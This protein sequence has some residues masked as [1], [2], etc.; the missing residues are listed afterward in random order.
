MRDEWPAFLASVAS[1][2]EAAQALELGADILDLKQ[3]ALGALGA[4]PIPAVA[5]AVQR[6]GGS[7][8]L[9]ATIGDVPALAEVVAPRVRATAATGVDF[10]KIGLFAG[11]DHRA[12]IEALVPAAAEARLVAVLMADEAPELDLLA[13]LAAAG[14]AG[15]MLDTADKARGGLRRHL[16]TA[17]LSA[18]VGI[19]RRH[20]LLCGLAGS[21]TRDDIDPLA[22]LAPDYLGFRGAL[23]GGDRKAGLDRASFQG[24]RAALNASQQV[25]PARRATATAGAQRLTSTS[26]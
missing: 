8:P 21:L 10:V 11:A 17:T 20:G 13:P 4:W 19:A 24:V 1:L 2:E 12:C 9:S 7:V 14:F 18:F 6:F 23:C 25:A 22:R 16:D 15:A 26:A 3:P 5:A